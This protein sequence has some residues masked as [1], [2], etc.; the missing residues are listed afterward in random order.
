MARITLQMGDITT[1][2]V[3]A[4]VNAANPSLLG[5]GG[6]D[7]AIHKA[8]GRELL[9]AC[10]EHPVLI[11]SVRCFIGQARAT[12]AFGTLQCDHVIHAVGPRY[13]VDPNPAA[14]LASAHRHALTLAV[15]LGCRTVA[16]PAISC[17]AY[18]Y[19]LHEAAP[20]AIAEARQPWDLDEIRF[21]LFD[22]RAM[23][24]PSPGL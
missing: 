24:A 2:E 13:Q 10:L 17:G 18:G 3:D 19:P 8:A 20:I 7:G 23:K 9:H 16:F 1:T 14:L 11:P 22:H 4:I 12:A 21:V 5:G 6:V 15:E